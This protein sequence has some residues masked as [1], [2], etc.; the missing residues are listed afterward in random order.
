M[1]CHRCGGVILQDDSPY[2]LQCGWRPSP[3]VLVEDK[4]YPVKKRVAWQFHR[5]LPALLEEYLIETDQ[6]TEKARQA[7]QQKKDFEQTL[8]SLWNDEGFAEK[9]TWRFLATLECYCVLGEKAAER[10]ISTMDKLKTLQ[11]LDRY[12]LDRWLKG[13]RRLKGGRPW[14]TRVFDLAI[15]LALCASYQWLLGQEVERARAAYPGHERKV[16]LSAAHMR[17]RNA[18]RLSR[19]ILLMLGPELDLLHAIL[20]MALWEDKY[21]PLV[22]QE[23]GMIADICY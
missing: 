9:I 12:P 15:K 23:K 17:L 18:H 6:A 19:R 8:R 22:L 2:C 14:N 13:G 5:L 21:R 4:P 7:L 10:L 16:A 1:R 20:T 3:T 11:H